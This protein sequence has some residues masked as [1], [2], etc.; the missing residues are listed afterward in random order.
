LINMLQQKQKIEQEIEQEVRQVVVQEIE[1]WEEAESNEK[2]IL[3]F[4]KLLV[5]Q[6]ITMKKRN[7][8]KINNL[9]WGA[10]DDNKVTIQL[11]KAAKSILKQTEYLN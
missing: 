9:N 10:L 3:H 11:L 6:N 2:N 1:E 8:S 4:L 7:I 5:E